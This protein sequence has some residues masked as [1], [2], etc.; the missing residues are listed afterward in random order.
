MGSYGTLI[1]AGAAI[2][3]DHGCARGSGGVIESIENT[4]AVGAGDVLL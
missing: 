3:A 1:F 4:W 2:G